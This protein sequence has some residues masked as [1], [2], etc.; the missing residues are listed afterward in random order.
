MKIESLIQRLKEI[1]PPKSLLIYKLAESMLLLQKYEK[2]RKEAGRK[3]WEN[4]PAHSAYREI[5]KNWKILRK[6]RYF[7]TRGKKAQFIRE[8]LDV[9][10]N[11]HLELNAE[12]L[13]KLMLEWEME[14]QFGELASSLTD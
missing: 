1:N 4:D 5:K 7:E 8:I 2:T 9:Y 12:H 14:Y 10:E 3:R 6:I 11:E 13:K